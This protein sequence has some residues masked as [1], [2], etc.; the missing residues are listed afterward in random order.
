MP[1]KRAIS[2]PTLPPVEGDL[3]LMGAVEGREAGREG[4]LAT[5][6]GVPI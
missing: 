5:L 1:L 3:E 2:D 6:R 4:V